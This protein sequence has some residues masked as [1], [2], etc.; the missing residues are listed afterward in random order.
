MVGVSSSPGP[1]N[2]RGGV[3]PRTGFLGVIGTEQCFICD[4]SSDRSLLGR[5]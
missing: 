5:A 4:F 1:R 2:V 3:T